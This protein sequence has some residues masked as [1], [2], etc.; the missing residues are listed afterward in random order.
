IQL[1]AEKQTY[2]YESIYVPDLN[3]DRKVTLY[4]RAQKTEPVLT[5]TTNVQTAN[6]IG[7]DIAS[8]KSFYKENGFKK[9]TVTY[10]RKS[11]DD[12]QGEIYEEAGYE[13][14]EL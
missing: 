2:A 1:G 8:L 10:K 11:A 4:I 7:V 13:D 12:V 3:N 5:A 6:Y 9:I 14:I